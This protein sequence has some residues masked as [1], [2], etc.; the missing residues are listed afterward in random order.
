MALNP[1]DI[2]VLEAAW[3]SS[4]AMNQQ[5]NSQTV[6]STLNG[7]SEDEFYDSL[8]IM[9]R[10]GYVKRSREI[11]PRPPSF[12]LTSRGV[13]KQ[14]EELGELRRIQ[15][16]V[17]QAIADKPDSTQSEIVAQTNHPPLVVAA[18]IDMLEGRGDIGV[19][20][21]IDGTVKI[22]QVNAALRRRVKDGDY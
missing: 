12:S 3:K 22:S 11:A 6:L 18:F 10:S 7:V 14:L 1:V 16:E 15:I 4:S 19:R 20:R 17:E 13:L 8:E 5:L 9:E 21:G 2:E